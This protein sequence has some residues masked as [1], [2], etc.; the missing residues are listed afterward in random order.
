MK[1]RR[2]QSRSIV[3]DLALWYAEH[4][5]PIFPCSPH[6]KEPLTPHGFKDATTDLQQ[7][8]EWWG[9]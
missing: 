8:R 2:Q 9:R 4:G 5:F 3:L 6:G 1:A 7:I